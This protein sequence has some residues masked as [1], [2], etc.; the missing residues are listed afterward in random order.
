MISERKDADNKVWHVVAPDGN[1]RPRERF[2]ESLNDARDFV[3]YPDGHV[4]IS[5]WLHFVR[6]AYETGGR[7]GEL[8]RAN[9]DEFDLVGRVWIIPSGHNKYGRSRAIPLGAD[10]LESLDVL[11]ASKVTDNPRVFHLL[12]RHA[13]TSVAFFMRSTKSLGLDCANFTELRKA[14]V[15]RMIERLGQAGFPRQDIA[16]V[17]DRRVV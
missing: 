15:E 17:I 4:F 13:V 11:G 7:I 9:W 2:F 3:G 5:H 16:K 6:L 12:T 8:L 14:A 10:A 1:L